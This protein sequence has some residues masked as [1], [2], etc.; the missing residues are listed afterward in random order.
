M[1]PQYPNFNKEALPGYKS[2]FRK[3]QKRMK[4]S[5][6]KQFRVYKNY[7]GKVTENSVSAVQNVLFILVSQLDS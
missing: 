6:F 3:K 1:M 5:T 2:I 4:L 7:F